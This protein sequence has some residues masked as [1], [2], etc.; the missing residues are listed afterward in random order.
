MKNS[1]EKFLKKDLAFI[2]IYLV[3]RVIQLAIYQYGIRSFN[4]TLDDMNRIDNDGFVFVYLFLNLL[5][6]TVILL[7]NHFHW[8]N[9]Q[10]LGLNKKHWSRNI[11]SGF[12]MGLIVVFL[13]NCITIV[14]KA[15][16]LMGVSNTFYPPYIFVY[17]IGFFIQVFH[18]EL[19][20]RGYVFHRL[21]EWIKHRNKLEISIGLTALFSVFIHIMTYPFSTITIINTF[22]WGIF[23]CLLVEDSH[24]IWLSVGFHFGWSYIQSVFFSHIV[25]GIHTNTTFLHIAVNKDYPLLTGGAY[26]PQGS[27]ITTLIM[28]ILTSLYLYKLRKTKKQS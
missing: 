2:L 14:L 4:M 13:Y 3:A 11:I 23:L 12:L 26:G 15:N 21:Q 7:F 17:L 6:L 1:K 9:P 16:I 22:L 24:D 18:G 8:K 28:L 25:N 19:L 5:P 27:L 20:I 10:E